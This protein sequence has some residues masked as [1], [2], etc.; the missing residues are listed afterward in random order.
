VYK[1]QILFQGGVA[2]NRGIK[3]A[4]EKALGTEVIVPPYFALMG[5]IGA[6]LL[7]EE[8]NIKKTKF[9]GFEI[10]EQNIITRGFECRGCSNLCEITNIFIEGKLVARLGGRCGKW[11]NLDD[12]SLPLVDLESY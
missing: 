8:A 2:A 9:K 6:G 12:T 3:V 11:E 4:F 7:A 1:R 5:A 10:A